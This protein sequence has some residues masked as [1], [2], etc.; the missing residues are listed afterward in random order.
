MKL[1][2]ITSLCLIS[3]LTFSADYKIDPE[4]SAVTFEIGHLGISTMSGHFKNFE[5]KFSFSE[6]MKTIST[7]L[8]VQTNSVDSNHEARDKHLRGPDFFD[9][10]QFPTMEFKG[11]NYENNTL[12][13]DLTLHGITRTVSFNVHKTGEGKDPWGGYRVGFIASTTIKRSEFGMTYFIPG[14]SDKTKVKVF[15]EAV[16]Q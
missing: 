5:G 2:N 14:A 8:S 11:K 15:I 7:H 3:S 16:R 10:K 1:I 4:H 6:D 12:T 9:V 13:G